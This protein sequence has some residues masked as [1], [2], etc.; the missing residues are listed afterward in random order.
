MAPWSRSLVSLETGIGKVQVMDA[1]V[2]Q[3]QE[4]A[5]DRQGTLFEDI[6]SDV[7]PCNSI[8]PEK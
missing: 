8:S 1:Y 7:L 3:L 4:H 5:P 2:K 6:E